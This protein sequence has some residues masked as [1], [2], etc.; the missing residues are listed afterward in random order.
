MIEFA[1]ALPQLMNQELL[2]VSRGIDC[3][4]RRYQLGVVAVITPFNFPAMVPL[5]MIPIAIGTG[6]TVIH[7]P[8]EQVP[9]TANVLAEYLKRAGMPNGV[10]NVIHGDKEV[11]EAITKQPLIKAIGFVGSS[12]VAK[13][14]YEQGTLNGKRVLALGGAKNHL[15]AMPDADPASTAANIV[16]SAF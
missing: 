1:T 7:K 12:P 10:Y 14:V 8:S 6:N 2:E 5:W 11:V 3:Y 13:L 16:A 9:L 4:N 15:V